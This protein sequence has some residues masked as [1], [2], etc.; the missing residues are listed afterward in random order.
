[1]EHKAYA[2][3]VVGAGPAGITAVGLL[4]DA[5]VSPEKIL[6][7]DPH[8]QVGDFGKYWG[9][10]NS[11]TRVALFQDYLN[12]VAHFDYAKK[13][14]SFALDQMDRNSFTVLQQVTE[15]LQWVTTRL[16][17]KIVSVS[18][19]VKSMHIEKGHWSLHTD[20]GVYAAEKVILGIG[21]EAKSLDYPSVEKMD[22][23]TALTP[24]QLKTV[25]DEHDQ[26]AVF[27]SSHSAMIIIRNL[28]EAGVKNIINFYQSPVRY[29]VLMQDWIL[30]DDT[31]LKGETAQWVKENIAKNCLPQVRRFLSTP[32]QVD[33]HLSSCNKAVYAVGFQ[34]RHIAIPGVSLT[35]YDESNGIIAPGL[36]GV[37]IGFPITVYDPFGRK[38]GNVG[39]WKFLKNLRRT[40]PIWQQYDI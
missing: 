5:G 19:Y 38:E 29:A 37:G 26:V 8:F 34:Q 7:I 22:L 32:E 17:E 33:A 4:L 31:G 21:S 12:G 24:S 1:M 6:W 18:G 2:W 23:V 39:L 20:Q 13:P 35:Q 27:G 28:V 11:N 36:F 40:L 3:A 25:C 30:Y 16:R 10:V 15:P 9:E 14:V